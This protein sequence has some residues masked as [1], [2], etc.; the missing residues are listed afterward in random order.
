ML[1]LNSLVCYRCVPDNRDAGPGWPVW[2]GFCP[3]AESFQL[4]VLVA[5]LLVVMSTVQST[6]GTEHLLMI[7]EILERFW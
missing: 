7:T 6:H 4:P 3:S 5:F 1:L 2:V